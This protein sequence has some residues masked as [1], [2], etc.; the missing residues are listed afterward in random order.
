[1][2]RVLAFLHFCVDFV[3]GDDWTAAVGVACALGATALVAGAGIPA[4]WLMPSAVL[5][6]LAFSLR[7]AT[8]P[9]R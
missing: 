2:S 1:M 5:A 9:S 7:R 6:I 8:R 3:V 4:W